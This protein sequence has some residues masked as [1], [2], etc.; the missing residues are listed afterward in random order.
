MENAL[1][2]MKKDGAFSTFEKKG[3]ALCPAKTRTETLSSPGKHKFI[4]PGGRQ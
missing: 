2:F 1:A 3:R 4:S